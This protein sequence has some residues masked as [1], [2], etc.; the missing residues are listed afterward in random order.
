MPTAPPEAAAENAE[1]GSPVVGEAARPPFAGRALPLL[2]FV[3][4]LIAALLWLSLAGTGSGGADDWLQA[5]A[6]AVA[7]TITETTA[8]HFEFRRQAF[9]MSLSE[10]PV[11]VG[12]F[13]VAPFPLLAARLV[14][15]GASFVIR[16][17]R[18]VVVAFNLPL[19]AVEIGVAVSVFR[20]I[21]SISDRT[22]DAILH[23]RPLSWLAA[24]AAVLAYDL[25]SALGVMAAIFATQARL[26]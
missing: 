12:L 9:S 6:L 15:A 21:G 3:L 25:V 10:A 18:P 24:F 19:F 1:E 11:V 2:I 4:V 8:L 16:R 17:T 23:A 7:V 14:G 13:F 26:R 22:S 20:A 5:L